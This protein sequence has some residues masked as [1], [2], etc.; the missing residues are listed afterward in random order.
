[1]KRWLPLLIYGCASQP[2]ASSSPAPILLYEVTH[3]EKPGHAYLLGTIHG[4]RPSDATLDDAIWKV[5][6]QGAPIWLESDPR[7][8]FDSKVML[9][10]EGLA[11]RGSFRASNTSSSV[12]SG[13]A[14][15]VS[16]KGISRKRR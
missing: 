13:I 12:R 6:D 11:C 10:P 9:L 2:I 3:P 16:S 1:V 7:K 14:R 4:R 15:S 5:I 8:P